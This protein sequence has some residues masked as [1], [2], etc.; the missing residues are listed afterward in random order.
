MT[1]ADLA[2][3][4]QA[5]PVRPART[6]DYVYATYGNDRSMPPVWRDFEPVMPW[7]I[8]DQRLAEQALQFWTAPDKAIMDGFRKLEDLVRERTG[9]SEHGTK[10]FSR[11]FAGEDSKLVWRRTEPGS[12]EAPNLIDPGEQAGRAQMF[13]GAYQAFRNPRAHRTPDDC[14]PGS[15]AEFLMLNQLFRL[16]RAADE[17]GQTVS[18]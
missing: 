13:I 8:V 14:S 3:V 12:S 6:F 11:A 10:L 15:L 16:E 18:Q 4:E 7:S 2:E 9:L 1:S 5:D 17:R